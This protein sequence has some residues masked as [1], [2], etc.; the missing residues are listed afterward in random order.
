MHVGSQ[1]IPMEKL[2]Q[3]AKVGLDES[4]VFDDMM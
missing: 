3:A 1:G 4:V 2:V